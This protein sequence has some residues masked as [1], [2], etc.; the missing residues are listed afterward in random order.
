MALKTV[1]TIGLF[2]V[3][4]SIFLPHYWT[5]SQGDRSPIKGLCSGAYVVHISTDPDSFFHAASGAVSKGC[6]EVGLLGVFDKAKSV[7]VWYWNAM[8]WNSGDG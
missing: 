1:R 3:F 8:K 2:F 6:Q 5:L 7:G 4:A